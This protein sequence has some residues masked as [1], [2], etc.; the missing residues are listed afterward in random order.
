ML[1]SLCPLNLLFL[2]QVKNILHVWAGIFSA[3]VNQFD[4]YITY[5]YI[6]SYNKKL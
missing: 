4:I 6:Y 2:A 5:I 3:I 1:S